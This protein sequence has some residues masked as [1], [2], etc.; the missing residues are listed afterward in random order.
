MSWEVSFVK[1][2][3][4]LRREAKKSLSLADQRGLREETD[5]LTL[6]MDKKILRDSEIPSKKVQFQE[7][8][9]DM[10]PSQP[11]FKGVTAVRDLCDEVF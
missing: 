9:H 6:K 2:G 8:L 4:L 3:L 1:A 11:S 5:F 10:L 7:E